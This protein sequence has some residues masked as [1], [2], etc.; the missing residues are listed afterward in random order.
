[1]AIDCQNDILLHAGQM[2]VPKWN[3]KCTLEDISDSFNK[4]LLYAIA[5]SDSDDNYRCLLLS[6]SY[7]LQFL[8]RLVYR[9][10]GRIKKLKPEEYN[11]CLFEWYLET[12][13]EVSMRLKEFIPNMSLDSH[14]VY[15]TIL[16][17]KPLLI[18]WIS[19][20]NELFFCS[21]YAYLIDY[22]IRRKGDVPY[23]DGIFPKNY[24]NFDPNSWIDMD[25][26]I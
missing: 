14:E 21:Q 20:D 13:E 26:S 17:L 18:K 16:G 6:L 15:N 9:S 1:M 11:K 4:H 25:G 12:E 24:F 2:I 7:E 22:V 10:R 23:P 5:Y 19:I 8:S 3:L